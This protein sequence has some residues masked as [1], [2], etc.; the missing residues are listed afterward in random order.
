MNVAVGGTNSYFPDGKC[1][2][3]YSNNDP[4]AV[5]TFWNNK[6]AW[7]PS[8]GKYEDHESALRV[9]WIKVFS[10]D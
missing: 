10:I 9:D 2:K 7:Y 5:N 6:G 3:P 1:N 4:K 8:W